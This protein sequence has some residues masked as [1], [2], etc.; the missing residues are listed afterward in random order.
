VDAIRWMDRVCFPGEA[1]L[2]FDGAYWWI[3]FDEDEIP[4]AYSSITYYPNGTAFLSR[5]GVLPGSRGC[6]LQRR[7]VYCRERQARNVG[8]RRIVS[9]TAKDNIVSGNNLIKCGY[10]LYIPEYEW[11]AK[12]AIYWEK[13]L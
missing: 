10:K 2:N 5:A 7:M 12:G 4:V 1:T 8:Y 3:A 13:K 9:Y 6:G 11:G